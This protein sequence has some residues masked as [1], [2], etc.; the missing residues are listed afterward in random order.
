MARSRNLAA[1]EALADP[2]GHHTDH[3]DD[4]GT[5]FVT[6][7]RQ[8]A[9]DELKVVAAEYGVLLEDLAIIASDR[10][11]AFMDRS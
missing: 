4:A 7:V 11:S 3:S 5:V 10:L 6:A 1:N 8:Q 9:T 2:N